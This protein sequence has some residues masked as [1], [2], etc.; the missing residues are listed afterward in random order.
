M[1]G[2]Y[3][4]K[5]FIRL[6]EDGLKTIPSSYPWRLLKHS[7]MNSDPVNW[8]GVPIFRWLKGIAVILNRSHTLP[9]IVI[10]SRMMI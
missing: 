10:G 9:I 7:I 1:P 6:G 4:L 2:R 8:S 3:L 5:S